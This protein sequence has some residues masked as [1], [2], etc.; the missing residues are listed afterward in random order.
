MAYTWLSLTDQ[1]MLQI[2]YEQV[3][4]RE[5]T[6]MQKA[7]NIKLTLTVIL[8]PH[9]QNSSNLLNEI[10]LPIMQTLHAHTT[11][12]NKMLKTIFSILYKAHI[13]KTTHEL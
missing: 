2:Y 5:K 4:L 13:N 6:C 7:E 10:T 11:F 9:T 3:R 8:K 12:C 1:C